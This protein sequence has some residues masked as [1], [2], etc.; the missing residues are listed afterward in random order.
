[1]NF[2]NN[3]VFGLY[4]NGYALTKNNVAVSWYSDGNGT[5]F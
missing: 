2:N 4:Q 5:T 1:M 3:M